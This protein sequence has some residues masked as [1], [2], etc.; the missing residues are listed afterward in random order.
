MAQN[1]YIGQPLPDEFGLKTRAFWAIE[2]IE[3][4]IVFI[5]GFAGGTRSTWDDFPMLLL[6]ELRC[7][8]HDIFY[9]GYE[10]ITVQA[11]NSVVDFFKFMNTLFEKPSNLLQYA[12]ENRKDKP[13][14]YG[15]VVIA[16]HSLGALMTRRCVLLAIDQ[17][18]S[19][20]GSVKDR[21]SVV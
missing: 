1:H 7:A 17:N 18:K 10:G 13:I 20:V 2:P 14:H 11:D 9:F 19:W 15:E 4:A 16:A 6:P 12:H 5:H 21:K 8:G 3:K